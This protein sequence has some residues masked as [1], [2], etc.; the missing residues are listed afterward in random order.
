M[1]K[2]VHTR[3]ELPNLE[4][5]EGIPWLLQHAFQVNDAAAEHKLLDYLKRAFSSWK[6]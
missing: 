1:E 6:S 4:T 2:F 5:Y 3:S